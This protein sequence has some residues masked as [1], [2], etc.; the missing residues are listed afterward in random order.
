MQGHPP[1]KNGNGDLRKQKAQAKAGMKALFGNRYSK[2]VLGTGLG[3][4][5]FTNNE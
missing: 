1:Q 3:E 5:R 2:I 4:F